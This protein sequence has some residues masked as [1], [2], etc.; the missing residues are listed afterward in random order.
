[1]G[2]RLPQIKTDFSLSFFFLISR[3][4][5]FTLLDSFHPETPSP[6]VGEGRGEGELKRKAEIPNRYHPHPYLPRSCEKIGVGGNE[7]HS[8]Y[9]GAGKIRLPK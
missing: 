1:M 9:P 4:S 8:P 6:L 7:R 5:G 2:H 3:K